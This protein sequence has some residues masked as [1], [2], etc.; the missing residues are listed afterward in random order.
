MKVPRLPRC[1]APKRPDR[2]EYEAQ[3]DGRVVANMTIREAVEL[4]RRRKRTGSE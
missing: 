2:L 3:P 1:E 4:R